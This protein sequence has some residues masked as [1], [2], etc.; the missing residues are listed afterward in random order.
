MGSRPGNDML[1]FRCR[2]G[3]PFAFDPASSGTTRSAH[4]NNPVQSG[5]ILDG[6]A[7][8]LSD[9]AA[10]QINRPEIYVRRLTLS[11]ACYKQ[12]T[13]VRSVCLSVGRPR[14][15]PFLSCTLSQSRLTSLIVPALGAYSSCDER[16]NAT[17]S[18]RKIVQPASRAA[19]DCSKTHRLA[20]LLRIRASLHDASPCDNL[21][22]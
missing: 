14:D 7:S 5:A 19:L 21:H 10:T 9:A 22:R 20:M 3:D 2:G 4:S 13:Q 17:R 1:R 18:N 6:V 11:P 15:L 12:R 16:G 8:W